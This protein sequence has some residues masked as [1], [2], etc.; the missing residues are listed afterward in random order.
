MD[1]HRSLPVVAA[2]LVLSTA[3]CED[4]LMSKETRARID[5]VKTAVTQNPDLVDAPDEQGQP[6]LHNAVVDSYFSLQMWLLDHRANPN[7]PNARGET[8]LHLAAL[9]DRTP[10]R[11][12]IRA[13]IRR[14]AD[15]NAVREDGSTPLHVAA[16]F[17][18]EA[19]LRAL[20][21]GGADPRRRSHRGD[22]PLHAA[23]TPQPDRTPEDCRRIIEQL[24]ARGADP[25][26]TNSY[27]M[28][29]LHQAALFGHVA[30]I[31]ALLEAGAR[32]D[33][34]GPERATALSLAATMGHAP[35]VAALLARGADPGHRD[36]AGR[37]PLEAA[38]ERPAT[39]YAAGTSG[40][41]SVDAVAA[42]LR[43]ARSL[44]PPAR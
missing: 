25:N 40:P 11:R 20:L 15:P 26:A 30:V 32:V 38:L 24:V 44:T 42:V 10:D 36:G 9:A 17:G 2:L 21:E 4:L 18:P 29:P 41:V 16:G 6:P 35:A 22:T 19:S 14:G 37:T 28:A 3:G 39:R 8:A 23:A 31:Q 5:A 13:L 34:E 33:L 27:G 43:Q 1:A 7:A 12:T